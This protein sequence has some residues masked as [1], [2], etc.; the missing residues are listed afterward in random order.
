MISALYPLTELAHWSPW[1]LFSISA[2]SS[3]GNLCSYRCMP[4]SLRLEDNDERKWEQ[5]CGVSV[6]HFKDLAFT[7]SEMGCYWRILFQLFRNFTF[8]K[9]V[10]VFNS[11]F[12][13]TL[14][15]LHREL[16]LHSNP[17]I[18]ISLSIFF[19]V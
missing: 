15:E 7:L 14:Q 12:T 3:K 4:G 8:K 9:I 13:E 2:T 1:C 11:Q 10:T 17:Q 16:M 19:S 6:A 5:D 18:I